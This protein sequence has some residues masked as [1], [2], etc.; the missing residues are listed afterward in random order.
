[1]DST[2]TQHAYLQ[3][4]QSIS[5]AWLADL[6]QYVAAQRPAIEQQSHEAFAREGLPPAF[7]AAITRG[8]GDSL[9]HTATAGIELAASQHAAYLSHIASTLAAG[10]ATGTDKAAKGRRT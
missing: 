10:A 8:L 6:R 4:I 5:A 7:D 3:A 1:M 2:Q 9:L